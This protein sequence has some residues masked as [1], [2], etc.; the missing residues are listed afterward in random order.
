MKKY[1]KDYPEDLVIRNVITKEGDR[2]IEIWCKQDPIKKYFS[3]ETME[4][5][6]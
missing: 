4:T 6:E 1:E 2:S 5:I 3:E